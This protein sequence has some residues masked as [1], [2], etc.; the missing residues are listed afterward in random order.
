MSGDQDTIACGREAFVRRLHATYA[1]PL[2]RVVRRYT[3]GDMQWAE[4]VVQETMLRAWRHT[5]LLQRGGY[6]SL[7]PWL[8]TVARN[9]VSNDRRSMRA[10]PQEMDAQLLAIVPAPDQTD[11]T[12]DRAVIGQAL[13]RLSK[14]QRDVIVA[15]YLHGRDLQDVARTLEV[16][17]GTVKSRAYY[18]LRAMRA[19]VCDDARTGRA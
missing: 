9:V 3:D 18:A 5:D 6:P 11:R 7:L 12:L 15:V 10:R 16:P 17:V 2:L 4:D 8:V 14:P 1:S 13:A 19:S